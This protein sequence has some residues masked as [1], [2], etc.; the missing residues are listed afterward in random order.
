MASGENTIPS[1][2][3]MR[4]LNTMVM[5]PKRHTITAAGMSDVN[6][7]PTA[8]GTPAGI[9]I[10]MFFSVQKCMMPTVTKPTTIA[11]SRPLE[12][13]P[14]TSSVPSAA[15]C[16]TTNAAT[17]VSTLVNMSALYSTAA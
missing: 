7:S 13:R 1:R 8:G 10:T 17:E 5:R 9:L 16:V 3:L 4:T 15:N 12:P 2:S 11:V 6:E 14:A